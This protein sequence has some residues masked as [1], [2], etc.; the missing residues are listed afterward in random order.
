MEGRVLSRT[1]D[2]L[3]PVQQHE[4]LRGPRLR[5][6]RLDEDP[7]QTAPHDKQGMAPAPGPAR[8]EH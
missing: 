1:A 4:K 3:Q 6:T 5:R 2:A 7:T 8:G